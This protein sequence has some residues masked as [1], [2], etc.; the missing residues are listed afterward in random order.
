M[1]LREMVGQ[2]HAV[3]MLQRAV[4]SGRLAHACLFDGPESVGKRSAALGLA[5]AL[6]CP[7][8][9]GA[10]LRDLR[11][12]PPHRDRPASRRALAGAGGPAVRHR[13]GARNRRHRFDAAARGPGAHAHPGSGG[14]PQ[15]QLGELSA[16]DPGRTL[17][18]QS[19]GARDLGARSVASHHSIAHAARS[20]RGLATR[21]AGRNR[22]CA[23]ARRA[24]RRKPRRRWPVGRSGGSCKRLNPRRNRT[25]GPSWATFARPR[26]PKGWA[27]SSMPRPSFPTR[28]A[29]RI[30]PRHWPCW[31]ASIATR[32]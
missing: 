24:R 19:P 5:M 10:W 32:S 29:G 26:R 30:C 12:L 31:P 9:P 16:Q 17:S 14:R 27:R 4:A 2:D 6:C 20:L 13:S 23:R 22:H 7:E 8:A 21:R 3:A 18:R 15:S 1:L 28:K 11:R 25:C